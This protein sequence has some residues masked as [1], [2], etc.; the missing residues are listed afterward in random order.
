MAEKIV[1]AVIGKHVVFTAIQSDDGYD[2]Y[3]EIE[4]AGFGEFYAESN[5]TNKMQIVGNFNPRT[6]YAGRIKT[7]VTTA[8]LAL[9]AEFFDEHR[10]N[11]RACPTNMRLI[12]NCCLDRDEDAN[13]IDIFDNF[14]AS[15]TSGDISAT[16]T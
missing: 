4:M 9:L 16:T 10:I 14:Y 2:I 13:K 1:I 11:K 12:Y 15:C 8:G 6:I 7:A 5:L 3:L